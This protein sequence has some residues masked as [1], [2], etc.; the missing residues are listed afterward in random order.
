MRGC[1]VC[2]EIIVIWDCPARRF[3][4]ATMRLISPASRGKRLID[5]AVDLQFSRDSTFAR[6]RLW[7]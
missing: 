5:L 6:S 1:G 4:R 2:R 7:R 3:N